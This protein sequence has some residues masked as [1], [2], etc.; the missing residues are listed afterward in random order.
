[1]KSTLL[2]PLSTCLFFGDCL[3]LDQHS[4]VG[5]EID[6]NELRWK[7]NYFSL[8]GLSYHVQKKIEMFS[9]SHEHPKVEQGVYNEKGKAKTSLLPS[10]NQVF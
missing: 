9:I 3:C 8:E 5:N 10:D 1:M 7:I 6:V 2:L 4:W